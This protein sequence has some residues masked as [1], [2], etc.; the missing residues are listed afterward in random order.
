LVLW[1]GWAVSGRLVGAD[2]VALTGSRVDRWAVV[3]AHVDHGVALPEAAAS[4][5]VSVRSTRRWVAAYRSGGLAALTR[6]GR[7][8]AGRWRL[9]AD[10]VQL[11][12]GWR[13]G[14]RRHGWPRCTVG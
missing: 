8:D 12:E 4:A 9:P 7:S 3:R 11:I 13:C 10:L 14:V 5:G 1:F 2:G 6:T